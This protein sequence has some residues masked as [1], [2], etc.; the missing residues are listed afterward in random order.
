MFV[1]KSH[2]SD[3]I[4]SAKAV[5]NII[6]LLVVLWILSR[7]LKGIGEYLY[8]TV[9][10]LINNTFQNI[11]TSKSNIDEL[12]NAKILAK[13][14]EKE[15]TSLTIRV[16]QLKNQEEENIRLRNLLNLKKELGYK[17][18]AAEVI[19]RS[20]DNWHKQIIINKGT[21]NGVSKGDAV[22]SEK[23]IVGQIVEVNE[24]TSS[25]QLISD[26]SYKIGCKVAGKDLIGILSG[27]TNSTGLLHFIPVGSDI[28]IGN[29]II[30][31]GI[32]INKVTSTYPRGY[33]LGKVSKISKKKNQFSDLYIEVKL[34][35]D[36][37]SIN[38]VVV[39]SSD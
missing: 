24:S 27:K 13:S 30:T 8:R 4:F 16:N 26:P 34:N 3:H 36:L 15:I 12:F 31:S 33:P 19:G 35:E 11:S 25:V 29:K 6:I 17:A 7:P 21:N 10:T 22:L 28:K 37:T 2:T 32:S 18:T 39:Y 38:N 1:K 9:G 20:P 5:F 14:K 23:G